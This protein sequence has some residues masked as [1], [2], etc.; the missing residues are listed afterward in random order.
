MALFDAL[1]PAWPRTG[2]CEVCRRWCR[3]A[4]CDDC[5]AR[6]A[7]RVPRCAGCALPLLPAVTRCAHCLREPPPFERCCCAVDYAFPWDALVT[8][9]KFHGRVELAAPLAGRLCA[10]LDDDETQW[11]D[12]VLP[13]PLAPARLAERGYNQSWELARRVA[14]ALQRPADARVLE[15]DGDGPHQAELN[16]AERQRSLR[17]AFRV[18]R[19]GQIAGRRVSLVD[20]VLTTGATA[21]EATRSLLQAGAAAVRVWTLARTP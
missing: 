7:V 3:G 9:F 11:P 18:A 4:L 20:D 19:A 15:R 17:G 5:T 16:R 12:L 6:H 1:R 8:A 14:A 2:Q 10:A 21:A 13:V